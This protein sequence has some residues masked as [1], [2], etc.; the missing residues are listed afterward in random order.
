MIGSARFDAMD[1]PLGALDAFTRESIQ[2]LVLRLWK[3]TGK[4]IV[5]ITHSI[6]EA[7][8]LGTRLIVMTPRPGRI[9]RVT[10]IAFGER[11][12]SEGDARAVKAGPEFI[13]MREE[14]LGWIQPDEEAEAA[15]ATRAAERGGESA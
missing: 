6:E 14:V 10:E 9:D 3:R 7:L 15:G 5:F 2:E 13:A 8:F 4:L 1:E 11:F 12:L